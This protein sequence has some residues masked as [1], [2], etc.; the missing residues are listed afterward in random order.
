MGKIITWRNAT[1]EEIVQGLDNPTNKGMILV[2]E[3]IIEEPEEDV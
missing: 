1:E 3:E 2:E